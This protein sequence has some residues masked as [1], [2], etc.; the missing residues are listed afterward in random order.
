TAPGI[1]KPFSVRLG[2]D[3]TVIVLGTDVEIEHAHAVRIGQL[4]K[5]RLS[6]DLR[7]PAAFGAYPQIALPPPAVHRCPASGAQRPHRILSGFLCRSFESTSHVR[8]RPPHSQVKPLGSL[9]GR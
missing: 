2:V 4:T 3:E 9:L 6:G 8:G 5:A 7:V 1:G